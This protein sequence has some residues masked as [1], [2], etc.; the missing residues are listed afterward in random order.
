MVGHRGDAIGAVENTL[1]AIAQAVTLG[2]DAVEVDVRRTVDG[3][4][5]LHHD[6]TLTR[7]HGRRLPVAFL[8]RQQLGRF[9]PTVPALADALDLVRTSAVPLV[10][11]VRALEAAHAALDVIAGLDRRAEL[12]ATGGVWFC[13]VPSVL[14]AVRQAAPYA[15]IMLSWRRFAAPPERLVRAVRPDWFNPWH[16]TVDETLV[17]NWRARGLPVST[18]TVDD[19][20]RRAQLATWGVEAFITN[21][22]GAAVA[23]RRRSGAETQDARIRLRR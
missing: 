14:A 1:P 12:L 13:G 16:R 20:E 18:W 5:V 2:A 4:A 8:T 17:A 21:D 9:A 3:V 11:D 7:L 22:I 23:E 6:V 15:R 19:A 10:L